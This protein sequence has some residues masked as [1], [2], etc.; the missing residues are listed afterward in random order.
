MDRKTG[1]AD[2][3]QRVQ[4]QMFCELL[5]RTKPAVAAETECGSEAEKASFRFLAD[6][7]KEE[8]MVKLPSGLMYRVLEKGTGKKHPGKHTKCLVNYRGALP[9]GREFDSSYSR[10]EPLEVAPNQVV[11]GWTEAMQLMVEGDKW[12]L[13]IPPNLGYG[14]EGAGEDIPGGSAL[15]FEMEMLKVE[16]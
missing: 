11:P 12:E 7:A 9:D 5:K 4:E 14:D 15:V 10:N 8:G 16:K 2:C 1:Q 6:K 3:Q 13:Y